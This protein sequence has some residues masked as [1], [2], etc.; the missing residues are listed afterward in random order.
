[1]AVTSTP[2]AARIRLTYPEGLS[3]I[4]YGA[5]NPS[6]NATQ[7]GVVASSIESLQVPDIR[8]AYLVTEFELRED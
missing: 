3:S 6:V 5:I 1:M 4:T 7:M 2:I 8:D